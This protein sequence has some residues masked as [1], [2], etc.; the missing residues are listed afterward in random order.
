MKNHDAVL[1]LIG[2]TPMVEATRLDTGP[3]RLFLKLENQNPG[4]SIKDRI[5]LSMIEAAERDGRLKPGGTIVE[6]TAGNTGLGL[7]LVAVRKG[8]KL[9]LVIPDKMSREKVF[10]LKAMGVEVVMTRS[11]VGKGHPDYYQDIAE[12]IAAET[13]AFYVNQFGNEANTYAH[14]TT[15]G[16]EIWEQMGHHVDA[17]VCGVGSAGTLAGLTRYF[18][19][20]SPATAMVLAD[21]VGSILVDVI[22]TGK[23][24]EAGSWLIEGIGEDFIPPIADLSGVKAAYSVSDAESFAAAREL[25]EK[26]GI[27]GGSST[28][29]LLAAA[30]E[31]CRTRNKPER[32]VSLVCDSGNKYL[33]KMYN[34]YWL[35]DMGFRQRGRHG[36]LRDLIGRPTEERAT[37]SVGP[38]D[39]LLTAFNRFKLNDVSQLPVLDGSRIVG[40]IDEYDVL[41]AVQRGES[42]FR[43][44]VRKHMTADLET[45]APEDTLDQVLAI[46]DR[47]H[48]AIIADA[49]AFHG[50]IT[51]IDLLNHLRRKLK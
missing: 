16:P 13:G 19:K 29:T 25:L 12:R 42:H 38:E 49:D 18:R 44:V 10:H 33:S 46:L 5:G 24:G 27:L 43:D 23:H 1:G 50:L 9:V 32:V 11:D 21:P 40:L 39:T 48:V 20:V 17:V 51:R 26:E 7:A 8:Y 47:D 37:V 22:K 15:T 14:E 35:A 41:R 45:L 3:C 28:G 31:Y 36:D 30:L 2:N 34:D 4:G 6:A